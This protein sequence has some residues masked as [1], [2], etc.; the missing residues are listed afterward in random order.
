MVYTTTTAN[1]DALASTNANN[2]FVREHAIQPS[3][4]LFGGSI[5]EFIASVTS[6]RTLVSLSVG[7]PRRVGRSVLQ[8]PKSPE[9]TIPWS[10]IGA[11]IIM[12]VNDL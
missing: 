3:T 7:P 11:L 5:L 6:L 4:L 10:Y 12:C 1:I 2:D 9:V 8:F